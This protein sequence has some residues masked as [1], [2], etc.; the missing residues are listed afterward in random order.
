MDRNG[1]ASDVKRGK[2]DVERKFCKHPRMKKKRGKKEFAA[3]W[4]SYHERPR[5]KRGKRNKSE[6]QPAFGGKKKKGESVE[7]WNSSICGNQLK[8]GREKTLKLS[9]KRADATGKKK[10]GVRPFCAGGSGGQEVKKRRRGRAFLS[11]EEQKGE[12]KRGRGFF[13]SGARGFSSRKGEKGRKGKETPEGAKKIH[14]EKKKNSADNGKKKN[15]AMGRLPV[16][17]K[18]RETKSTFRCRTG[19]KKGGKGRRESER[20]RLMPVP[21]REK[22]KKEG[23]GYSLFSGAPP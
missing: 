21:E 5:T 22:R 18:K 13:H 16:S 15:K 11:E 7:C 9:S 14:E 12:G 2:G 3:N 6:K 17:S 20:I 19:K 8:K 23:E 1:V 10:K 4:F